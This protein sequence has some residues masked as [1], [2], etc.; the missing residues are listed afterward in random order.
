M[1]TKKL[2]SEQKPVSLSSRSVC[3]MITWKAERNLYAPFNSVG[4]P[5]F[6]EKTSKENCIRYYGFCPDILL[7]QNHVLNLTC[8]SNH[9][10]IQIMT[11]IHTL[12]T[13]DR[14]THM[15]WF[16]ILLTLM[17]EDRITHMMCFFLFCWRADPVFF[18]CFWDPPSLPRAEL[19]SARSVA[20]LC[21]PCLKQGFNHAKTP[22]CHAVH[23]I[24]NSTGA[25][26][27]Y[28]HPPPLRAPSNYIILGF[29]HTDAP[30]FISTRSYLKLLS[31][32]CWGQ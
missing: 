20:K 6:A 7:L 29:F 26:W 14:I 1:R 12:I 21:M 15:L 8:M 11:W 23:L 9:I 28:N 10:L 19:L 5:I 17:T 24:R 2:W 25:V 30:S 22:K 16:F 18:H 13:E 3:I 32:E 31:L 4:V 27:H